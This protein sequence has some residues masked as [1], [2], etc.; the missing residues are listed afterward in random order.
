VSKS[1]LK[2]DLKFTD[3][4]GYTDF[5]FFAVPSHL[6][7]DAVIKAEDSVKIGVLNVDTQQIVKWPVRQDVVATNGF[8]IMREMLFKGI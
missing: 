5:F 1:D 4:L 7:D 6:V 2:G 3:Y 8:E